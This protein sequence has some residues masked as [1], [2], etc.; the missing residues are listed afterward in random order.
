M[1]MNVLDVTPTEKDAELAKVAQRCLMTVLDH[2][3]ANKIAL[4]SDDGDVNSAPTIELPPSALRFLAEV[5]GMMAERQPITLVPQSHELT[6]QDVA[7]LLNVSRP[8]VVKMIEEKRMKCRKVGRHRRIEMSEAMRVRN[9]MRSES[10]D[11]LKEL[12]D[13]SNEFGLDLF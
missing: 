9:E 4:I 3:R 13:T 10:Q 8:F 2:S 12:S 1:E 5:L 6:T 7:N 11:G